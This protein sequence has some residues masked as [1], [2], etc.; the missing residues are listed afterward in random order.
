M[1]SELITRPDIELLLP[2]IGGTWVLGPEARRR[3]HVIYADFL[4]QSF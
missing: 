2:P 4:A 1:Y 3:G